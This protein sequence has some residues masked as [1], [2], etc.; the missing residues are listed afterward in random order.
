[1]FGA[2]GRSMLMTPVTFAAVKWARGLDDERVW[3]IEDC[4]HVSRR[5]EQALIA[6]GER[7]IPWPR[8]GWAR[9][10]RGSAS[11]GN[12]TRS[13]RSRSPVRSSKTALS[14]SQPLSWTS[15]RWRSGCW[16]ITAASRRRAHP[17]PERRL[18][19]RRVVPRARGV[20]EEALA[21]RHPPTRPDRPAAA[22]LDAETRVRIARERVRRSAA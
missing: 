2:A 8:I 20:A 12:L 21:L 4:R 6:A 14:P 11:R 16:P 22:R 13:T 18:A 9:R 1:M 17:D 10:V 3:A 5:L 19:S 15:G 7:V